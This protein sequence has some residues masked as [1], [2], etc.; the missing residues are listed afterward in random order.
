MF[1]GHLALLELLERETPGARNPLIW[2][3]ESALPSC[4]VGAGGSPLRCAFHLIKF[5][6]P[7]SPRPGFPGA[8]DSQPQP[9]KDLS[10]EPQVGER[11][12]QPSCSLGQSWGGGLG[13]DSPWGGGAAGLPG[14]LVSH[15]EG[16][17]GMDR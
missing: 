6:I 14:G 4:G 9:Q 7:C 13:E 2:E 17:A 10:L 3:N 1:P 11:G 12:L 16:T 8:P 15:C 5:P